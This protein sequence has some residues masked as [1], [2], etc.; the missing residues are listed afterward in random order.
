[1]R[2]PKGIVYIINSVADGTGR[3]ACYTVLDGSAMVYPPAP[4]PNEALEN[5]LK[6]YAPP[7]QASR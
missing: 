4:T 7:E 6:M 1:M 2:K 5:A 3:W